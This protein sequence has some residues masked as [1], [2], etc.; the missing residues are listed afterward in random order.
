MTSGQ[1]TFEDLAALFSDLQRD[2]PHWSQRMIISQLRRTMPA[3]THGV[4][5]A[6]M[7]FDR[8]DSELGDEYRARFKALRRRAITENG[9]DL[10]HVLTSID[11]MLSVDFIRNAYASWAGDLGTHVLANL[12]RQA[13]LTVGAP[14]SPAGLADLHGDIDGDNIATHMPSDKP[15]AA[16]L[17]YYQ[18]D[19]TCMDGVT[20][21]S[22]FTTFARDQG[23]LDGAGVFGV[24]IDR[25]RRAFHARTRE[26][27]MFEELDL[28]ARHPLKLLKDL[29]EADEKRQID[30]LLDSA[31]DQFLAIIAAGVDVELNSH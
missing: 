6:A 3:Y 24:D 16:V 29:F 18:R 10:A 2:Y 31:L 27:I 15:L 26:F 25:A 8:G 30:A 22:R 28:D 12:S 17:A 23:L 21:D 13:S 11:V 1:Y 9:F 7:P 5:S 4:W 19:P 20:V 14:D